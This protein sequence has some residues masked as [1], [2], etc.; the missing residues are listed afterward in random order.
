MV[1]KLFTLFSGVVVAFS[2]SCAMP[3]Q[4]APVQDKSDKK[5]KEARSEGN[6]VRSSPDKSTLTVRKSG[7]PLK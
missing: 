1:R 5:A 3:A 2:L 6:V 4:D 7:E